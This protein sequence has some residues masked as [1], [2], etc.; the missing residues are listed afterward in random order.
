MSAQDDIEYYRRRAA[1]EASRADSAVEPLVAA[2]H[3]NLSERYSAMVRED[4][5]PV[6]QNM[7]A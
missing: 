2:V 4:E 5:E 6:T 7:A 3:R 1:V